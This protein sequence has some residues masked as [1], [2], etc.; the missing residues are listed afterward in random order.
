MA[1]IQSNGNRHWILPDRAPI[2]GNAALRRRTGRL[3]R[4]AARDVQYGGRLLA[5]TSL[6]TPIGSAD[7][8][9]RRNPHGHCIG[10]RPR[11]HR[12][13]CRASRSHVLNQRFPY[14]LALHAVDVPLLG[15]A[16][17]QAERLEAA[18]LG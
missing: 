12:W 17:A 2:R 1:R 18:D 9:L 3:N 8:P 15:P 11:L 4:W 7:R 10:A 5:S 14:L 13:E 16:A 6:L